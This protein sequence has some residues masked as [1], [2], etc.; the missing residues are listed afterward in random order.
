MRGLSPHGGLLRI[1]NPYIHLRRMT[2]P[3][4][5]EE[6]VMKESFILVL[7]SILSILFVSCQKTDDVLIAKLVGVFDNINYEDSL[8]DDSENGR[9]KRVLF[10]R[11]RIINESDR[12]YYLP[13]NWYLSDKKGILVRSVN[14]EDSLSY[15][16]WHAEAF[17]TKSLKGGL[18]DARDTCCLRFDMYDLKNNKNEICR[19]PTKK[20]LSSLQITY[21]LES[22][23]LYPGCLP[24]PKIIFE[25]NVDS[26]VIEY[27]SPQIKGGKISARRVSDTQ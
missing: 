14:R 18:L 3:P 13:L 23:K 5:R 25:N 6:L 27:E 24:V 26:I 10:M 17:G 16:V 15:R 12:S 21:E 7:V 20:I 4:E 11:Y 19:M 22:A 8:F 2:Y 1:A 9:F